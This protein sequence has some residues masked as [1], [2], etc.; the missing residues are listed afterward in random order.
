MGILQAGL[1]GGVRAT[2]HNWI[3]EIQFTRGNQGLLT[4]LLL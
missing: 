4:Y 1:F 3:T 2:H